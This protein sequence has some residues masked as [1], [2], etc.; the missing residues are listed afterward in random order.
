MFPED[1]RDAEALLACS[2]AR[3]YDAKR[4][5]APHARHIETRAAS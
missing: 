4:G 3:M 1:G 5:P 2:D